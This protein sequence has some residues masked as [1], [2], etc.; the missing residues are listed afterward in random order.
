MHSLAA[1]LY[2]V[3]VNVTEAMTLVFTLAE[4]EMW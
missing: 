3:V 2:I 4:A 1:V